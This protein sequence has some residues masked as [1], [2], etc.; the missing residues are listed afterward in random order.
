MKHAR[1]VAASEPGE[2][3]AAARC[4]TSSRRSGG[5]IWASE[6][7]SRQSVNRSKRYVNG[8]KQFSAV[9]VLTRRVFARYSEY[10]DSIER[11][12]DRAKNDRP[13]HRAIEFTNSSQLF[14][15]Q[16]YDIGLVQ[17]I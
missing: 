16:I 8:L 4:S 2:P 6:A 15:G 3:R 17:H 14:A 7:E 9:D 10:F 5:Y 11:G 13:A 12:D 1:K